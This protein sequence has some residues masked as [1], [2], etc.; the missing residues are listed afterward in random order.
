MYNTVCMSLF[1]GCD[2][3]SLEGFLV[4][5]PLWGRRL[6]FGGCGL[7]GGQGLFDDEDCRHSVRGCGQEREHGGDVSQGRGVPQGHP[8]HQLLIEDQNGSQHHYS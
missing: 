5:A 6:A 3:K 1:R 2:D 4:F 8:T 7:G